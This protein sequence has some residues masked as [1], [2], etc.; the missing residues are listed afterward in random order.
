MSVDFC[1]QIQGT[2][3]QRPNIVLTWVVLHNILRIHQGRPDRAPNP[4]EYIS[5]RSNEAVYVTDENHKN[6]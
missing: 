6:P 3:E 4:A 2:M 5:A 1:K